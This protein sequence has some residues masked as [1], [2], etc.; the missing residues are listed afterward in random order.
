MPWPLAARCLFL[1][2]LAAASAACSAYWYALPWP[3]PAGVTVIGF[4]L[5]WL[6]FVFLWFAFRRHDPLAWMAGALVMFPLAQALVH[7]V[8]SEMSN[9]VDLR[10]WGGFVVVF[11]LRA[12]VSCCL[13]MAAYAVFF[14]W[15]KMQG[16]SADVTGL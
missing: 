13:C 9:S 11:M 7:G 6:G 14:I 4:A 3:K 5:E 12:M 16:L 15:R 1:V 10:G 8:A 2:A